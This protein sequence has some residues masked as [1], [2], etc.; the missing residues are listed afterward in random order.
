MAKGIRVGDASIIIV[1]NES[2]M[3]FSLTSASG[4]NAF[5][6]DVGEVELVAKLDWEEIAANDKI[7]LV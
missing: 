4:S 2:A 3:Q 7:K 1:N 6:K 5:I